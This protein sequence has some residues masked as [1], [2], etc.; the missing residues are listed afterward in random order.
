MPTVSE[1]VSIVETQIINIGE[2]IDD[3]KKD[4]HDNRESI[5]AELKAMNDTA[6][7]AHAQL[8]TKIGELEQFRN[9]WYYMIVGGAVVISFFIG[10][11]NLV[12]GFFK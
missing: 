11:S 1:R 10:N 7:A 5:V 3:L 6:A 12:T 9:K 2:K 4:L 8:S